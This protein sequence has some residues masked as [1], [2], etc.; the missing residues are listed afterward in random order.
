M[1]LKQFT[2]LR[3][4]PLKHSCHQKKTPNNIIIWGRGKR[5]QTLFILNTQE[6]FFS[7]LL[8][9]GSLRKICQ[10]IRTQDLWQ[11]SGEPVFNH[12][13]HG[14]EEIIF[15]AIVLPQCYWALR[16]RKDFGLLREHSGDTSDLLALWRL[17][18][19]WLA[20]K[21]WWETFL[22]SCPA[23]SYQWGLQ[24]R[25]P[26]ERLFPSLAPYK[27]FYVQLQTQ[28]CTIYVPAPVHQLE[29]THK[30]QGVMVWLKKSW[31][32]DWKWVHQL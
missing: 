20:R 6:P 26:L 19:S 3:P 31:K 8:L 21:P 5:N 17:Q 15:H 13:H 32:T 29:N 9:Q 1:C 30:L 4:L 25:E 14:H 12:T 23:L 28:N 11:H 27:Y 24:W 22:A 7:L 16:F 10:C 18:R 2:L